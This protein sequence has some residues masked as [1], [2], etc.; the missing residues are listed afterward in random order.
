MADVDAIIVKLQADLSE[1]RS[2]LVAGQKLVAQSAQNI[3]KTLDQMSKR[4]GGSF[5]FLKNAA[6]TAA[7]FISGS[8]FLGAVEG[9]ASAVLHFFESGIEE[10][11]VQ[12]DVVT[13][14]N[15][16]MAQAGQYS[17]AASEDMQRFADTMQGATKFSDDMVL[18]ASAQIEALGRLST[19]ALKPAT[20]AALDMST[21]LG[22]DL[23][24]AATVVGKAAAGE[25]GTLTRYGIAVSEGATKAETFA[26]ALSALNQ[27][28]GGSAANAVKTYSGA[29]QQLA[30]NYA[31][32]KKELAT[33]VTQSGAVVG[34]INAISGAFGKLAEYVKNNRAGLQELVKDGIIILADGIP[35]AVKALEA[36]S[37]GFSTTYRFVQSLRGGLAQL[38]GDTDTVD[39]ALQ[40]IFESQQA[41]NKRAETF[42]MLGVEAQKLRDQIVSAAENGAAAQNEMN[43]ALEKQSQL[44]ALNN[45]ALGVLTETE[46]AR[47]EAQI[48]AGQ[49]LI[50]AEETLNTD[51][52]ALLEKKQAAEQDANAKAYEQKLLSKEQFEARTTAIETKYSE[53]RVKV[54]KAEA[55]R[56]YKIEQQQMKGISD[57]LGNTAQIAKAFGKDGFKA[58]QAIASAQAT[59]DAIAGAQAAYK[60]ALEIPVIGLTLA[61]IAAATALGAGLARVAAIN[62]QKP[63]G[64]AKG[65]E[66][67]GIGFSDSQP[68]MLTPGETVIDRSTTSQLKKSLS[69]DNAL[70]GEI[71]ALRGDIARMGSFPSVLVI[72]DLNG[73]VFMEVINEQLRGGRKLAIGAVS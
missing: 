37:E 13:R 29:T 41:D 12:E 72:K 26:N 27:H 1:F 68:A 57:V 52:L 18:S 48:E 54:A 4:G 24:T 15:S 56:K 65:G 23:K 49:K 53:D 42:K 3:E 31:D 25:V 2:E 61:P 67:P 58:Y 55:D 35:L 22:I 46:N 39:D 19:D 51:H 62:S 34:A 66:V 32:V 73:R 28:F 21:A 40:K 20:K 44:A 33:T 30:N 17:R 60:S 64:F 63:T 45:E 6:A 59:I 9:A 36:V 14:L 11:K 8:A 70:L 5:S 50:E 38:R 47:L 69:G 16:S 10:A 71:Q 43:A 7:G